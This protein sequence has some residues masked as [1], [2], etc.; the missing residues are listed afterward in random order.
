MQ[1]LGDTPAVHGEVRLVVCSSKANSLASLNRHA[2]LCGLSIDKVWTSPRATE[3]EWS[4][5]QRAAQPTLK[6]AAVQPKIDLH[7]E[8]GV[9]DCV[10][11]IA[12]TGEPDAA[13]DRAQ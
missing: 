8:P 12:R 13:A 7:C 10:V 4:T 9:L 5:R 2:E 1:C 11:Q 3:V 6:W